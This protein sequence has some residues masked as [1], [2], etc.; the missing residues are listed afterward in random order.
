MAVQLRP[1]RDDEFAEWL[2]RL[3]DDYAQDMGSN[4]QAVF[5]I[6]ADGE[7]AGTLWVA[8]RDEAEF[9]SL[10]VY[11]LHVEER[12]RGRGYGKAAM[13]LAEEEARRRG[14]DCIALNV[15]GGNTVARNLYRSLGYDENAVAMSKLLEEGRGADGA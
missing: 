2:P 5:V 9:R 1:M 15:S 13:V 3:R 11:E 8:D 4:E 14:I 10:F 7:S 6:E 12:Y